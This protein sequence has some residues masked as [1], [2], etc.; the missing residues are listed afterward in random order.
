[1]PAEGFLSYVRIQLVPQDG[2]GTNEDKFLSEDFERLLQDGDATTEGEF[3]ERVC[4]E[5]RYYDPF[6][7]VCWDEDCEPRSANSHEECEFLQ[8]TNK[9]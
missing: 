4:P 1:M 3:D 7:K 2:D 9:G 5:P 8:S 6:A